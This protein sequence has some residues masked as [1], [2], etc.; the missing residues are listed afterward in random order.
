M[1]SITTTYQ[2]DML[3]E[4]EIG[5]NQI[6]VDAPSV[7]GGTSRGI[8]PS[9]LFIASLGAC[10]AA[11]VASYCQE[12]GLDATGLK[13]DVSFDH[14]D[15]PHRLVNIRA[16]VILPNAD[17][18]SRQSALRRVAMRCPVHKTIESWAG[19][20]VDIVGAETTDPA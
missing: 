8:T 5:G 17:F 9:E 12:H 2:G 4:M 15:Y 16:K 19:L 13:V 14:S 20:N 11:Y 18:R 7:I 10:I 6:K 3:F 1:S